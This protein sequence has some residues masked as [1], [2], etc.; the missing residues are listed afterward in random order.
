MNMVT[1]ISGINNNVNGGIP[2]MEI[3]LPPYCLR[4]GRLSLS[5]IRYM[6]GT[7]MSVIKN[8]NA[9]PKI[10]VHESGFQK[11]ALSPPKN[12]WG[13]RSANMVTKLIL[14]PIASGINAS[15]AA[16]AVTSARQQRTLPGEALR[17]RRRSRRPADCCKRPKPP[18]PAN[19]NVDASARAR[20][21][22]NSD[23]L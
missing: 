19:L 13:L 11:R 22:T 17:G 12:M 10:I 23:C 9:S 6:L 4:I 14:K 5:A 21:T 15:I 16:S 1:S 20:V 3:H 2:S 18:S 7:I 8:A